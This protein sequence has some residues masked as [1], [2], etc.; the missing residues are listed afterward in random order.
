MRVPTFIAIYAVI[1]GASKVA[2]H[3][4]YLLWFE[5]AVTAQHKIAAAGGWLA[6]ALYLGLSY[7]VLVRRDWARSCLSWSAILMAFSFCVGWWGYWSRIS[8][9]T[10]VQVQIIADLFSELAAPLFLA[11]LLRLPAV[12]TS[13]ATH[14]EDL[15]NI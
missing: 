1:V 2:T 15:P 8:S 3:A 6:G 13:F 5:L 7:F 14:Q 12:R 9:H 11:D 10:W 4:I